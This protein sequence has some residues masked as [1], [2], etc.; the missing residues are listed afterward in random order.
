MRASSL[1]SI[2]V[3]RAESFAL[4]AEHLS[5]G[6][7]SHLEWY[8]ATRASSLARRASMPAP[9]PADATE[10]A[11][12]APSRT[13]IAA[14]FFTEILSLDP[15]DFRGAEPRKAPATEPFVSLPEGIC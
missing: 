14:T 7:T 12:S 2:L 5:L 10:E 9:F 4:T 11:R 13:T 1:P 6:L 3:R 15:I 8:L